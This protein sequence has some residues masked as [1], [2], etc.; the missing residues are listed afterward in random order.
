M[1][2][3]R[4]DESDVVDAEGGRLSARMPGWHVIAWGN[5]IA[6][7]VA[8]AVSGIALAHEPIHLTAKA[9]AGLAYLAGGSQFGAYML[10]Y[11][12]WGPS[13]WPAPA[14][15]SSRSRW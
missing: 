12:G 6:A 7:P 5:V 3:R 14:N 15:S 13:A 1:R 9:V 11:R 8:F 10:W 4:G 2:E